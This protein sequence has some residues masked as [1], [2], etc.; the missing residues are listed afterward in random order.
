MLDEKLAPVSDDRFWY[1]IQQ[2]KWDIE[3]VHNFIARLNISHDYT[4]REFERIKKLKET[5]NLDYPSDHKKYFST[6]VELMKKMRSTLSAYKKIIEGFRPKKKRGRNY[7]NHVAGHDRTALFAGPY[8]QDAFG[9]EGY[10]DKSVKELLDALNS[11]LRLSGD[12]L[13]TCLDIIDEENAIRGNPELAYRLYEASFDR[14]VKGNRKLI[15]LM[16]DANISI[17]D[18]ILKA[19][20]EAKDIKQLIA[21]LFHE[22]NYSDFNYHCACKTVSDGRK[23][24]LT[25]EE[26]FLFGKDNAGRVLRIRTLLDHIMELSQQRDDVVGWEGM[27]SGCFVMHLLYWC[28]WDG[29]KNEGMLTYVAN[30]C[31]GKISCVKMSAVQSAKRKAF[32]LDNEERYR[33][34]EAFDRDMDS[35]VDGLLRQPSEIS[36]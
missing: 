25:K 27:L 21:T 2:K 26:A 31:Q 18:D 19:M 29:S 6:A 9:W 14:S 1:S 30:R 8:S 32:R 24:G 35:F 15:A 28:G 5:Y 22:I 23:A 4:Q 36:N 34:Q 12:C 11:Y 33:Q 17:D 16:K 7:D 10:S 3:S 13:A 20:E